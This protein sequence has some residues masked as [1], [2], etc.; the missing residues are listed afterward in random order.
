MPNEEGWD[1]DDWADD[2]IKQ[3]NTARKKRGKPFGKIEYQTGVDVGTKEE[4]TQK[5]VIKYVQLKEERFKKAE[6][7]RTKKAIARTVAKQLRG[8][9]RELVLEA[10]KGTK[11]EEQIK[12]LPGGLKGPADLSKVPGAKKMLTP[13]GGLNMQSKAFNSHLGAGSAEKPAEKFVPTTWEEAKKFADFPDDAGD[14]IDTKK[15]MDMEKKERIVKAN[16]MSKG[17]FVANKLVPTNPNQQGAT[18]TAG[19]QQTANLSGGSAGGNVGINTTTVNNTTL[20]ESTM[21]VGQQRPVGN[22]KM[23]NL[24]T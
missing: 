3:D 7:K 9:Q 14:V 1:D 16:N 5:N 13:S 15:R 4:K 2:L 10:L 23:R 12:K 20:G 6:K 8:P 17:T 18:L 11:L 24:T 22:P 21:V 19:Q